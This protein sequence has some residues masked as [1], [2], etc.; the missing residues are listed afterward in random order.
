MDFCLASTASTG[1]EHA[2]SAFE[3]LKAV[4]NSQHQDLT[5]SQ[6]EFL[7][8]SFNNAPPSPTLAP[9]LSSAPRPTPRTAL[10]MYIPGQGV[11][12]YA[13]PNTAPGSIS[14]TPQTSVTQSHQRPQTLSFVPAASRVSPALPSGSRH[15]SAPSSVPAASLESP[16]LPSASRQPPAFQS[17]A[18][19]A[20]L[21]AR[22]GWNDRDPQRAARANATD[23]SEF[24]SAFQDTSSR[25]N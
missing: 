6:A 13:V 2:Q 9:N 1:S 4:T 11:N 19:P 3:M 18:H 10:R 23:H 8:D 14:D 21:E 5:A 20:A 22:I 25:V 24:R 15:P 7:A 17:S 12:P 16:A